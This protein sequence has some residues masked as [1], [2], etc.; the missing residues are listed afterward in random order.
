MNIESIEQATGLSWPEWLVF[1]ESVGAKDLTHPQIARHAYEHIVASGVLDDTAANARGR[2]NSSGWWSQN[3]TVAYE[4]HI[5]RRKPGQ[6]AD[7]TYE[8]SVTKSIG[9]DMADAFVWWM[10]MVAGQKE[11]NGVE[12]DGEPRTSVTPVA[13]NWRA[14]LADGSK[15][16]VSASLRNSSKAMIAIT[17]QKLSSSK[18][19]EQW[20]AYWKQFLSD[21]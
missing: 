4:Q 9:S 20:R 18:D 11:F 12:L 3:V 13:H 16:L 19:A 21:L 17:V 10:D 14:D 5:G 7:G 6:R 1:F 8:V 15:L 2:Q